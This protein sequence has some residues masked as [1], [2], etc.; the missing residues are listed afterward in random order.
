MKRMLM[1]LAM[2]LTC[3][4]MM[5]AQTNA[6]VA[7]APS[8]PSPQASA[9]KSS[10]PPVDPKN[11]TATS[12]TAD[13]VNS[14]LKAIWGYDTNRIWSV[15]AVQKTAAPG[16]AKVIVFV[17]DAAQPDKGSQTVFFVTPDGKHAIAGDVVDFG[18]TPFAEN[19]ALLEAKATGPSRGAKTNTL[20]LVE[21]A[22][23]QCPHCKDAQTTMEQLATDFPQAK[24][25]FENF[26][27]TE[28][29]PYALEAAA[30]G[31][32]VRKAKGDA[33]FFTY[34][35]AVFETQGALTADSY[36]TTLSSAAERAGADPVAMKTCAATQAAKDEA[37]ASR[38]LGEDIGVNQT[39]MLAVN[40]HLLPMSEMPYETL[41]KVVAY[42]AAQD[43]VAVHLQPT[44][45]TLK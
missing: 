7:A 34:A 43:G 11:F 27:L 38:K 33:A 23:M 42:Q 37:L 44:L 16:V 40:G 20:E 3:A 41:K 32:C 36:A 25:V 19:R 39:P 22:D 10:F 21:F 15:A 17:A 5:H 8:A 6:P 28:I 14:F 13:D 2:A 29:H 24:I 12:P 1:G 4:G 26:P 45:S 31:N 9:G 18:A 30:E 35:S